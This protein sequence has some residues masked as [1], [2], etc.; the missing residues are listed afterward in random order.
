VTDKPDRSEGVSVEL[1]PEEAKGSADSRDG[2]AQGP[3]LLTPLV[4]SR[5][6]NPIPQW[7]RWAK[8]PIGRLL[9]F[10]RNR[11]PAWTVGALC[12]LL[13]SLG[14]LR[15]A[16]EWKELLWVRAEA[17]K[18]YV[19]VVRPIP[20]PPYTDLDLPGTTQGYHETP[21]WAR[22]SGYI[23][24]WYADIGTHVKEGDLLCEIEAPE[25]D[26]Q[27]EN[28]RAKVD[29][30]K[31]SLDRY[32]A[33]LQAHAVSQQDV[34][35][36]RTN[37]QAAVADLNRW[38]GWQAFEKVRAPFDGVITARNIDIGTLVAGQNEGRQG[39]T[40]QLYRIAKV[41]V[42]RVYVAVPQAYA[43]SV[44]AGLDCKVIIPER[45]DQPIQGKVVRTSEG[46]EPASRTL[47][48]EVDIQN[49]KGT[50]LP[51]LYVNVRFHL[52]TA[53]RYTVP[54]NTLLQ[55]PEGQYV[56]V[57]DETNRTR[58]KRVETGYDDGHKVEILGGLTGNDR[59]V[60]NPSD[61]TRIEG[62][63]VTIVSS[64]R[65]KPKSAKE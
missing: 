51:G 42:L 54:V 8:A 16:W 52:P 46:L 20:T 56:V 38:L 65:A 19:Q 18:V 61:A 6:P 49:P 23:K 36:W 45:P 41:D 57:V 9:S 34:D 30:A 13:L 58:L 53:G 29:L 37:Y 55:R 12:L 59:I 3:V 25:V 50:I 31:V 10:F 39:A 32:Q 62:T 22:V 14:L 40:H 5:F 48:T 44:R 63:L 17:S 60:L 4:R 43:L 64:D 27:V 28:S 26:Q 24:K 33:L 47:L 7:T 11:H 1:P 15:K 35:Y 2:T 21:I